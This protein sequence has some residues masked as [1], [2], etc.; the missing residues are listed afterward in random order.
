MKFNLKYC[1]EYK[2]G[3]NYYNLITKINPNYKLFYNVKDK[4]FII[5]NSAKN[6]EI[7]LN[8]NNFNQNI[9]KILN[10]SKVENSKNIFYSIENHNNKLLKKLNEKIKYESIE[11]IKILKNYL[12]KTPII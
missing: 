12:S 5:V 6:Y 11:Q 4:C 3:F 7:C 8:F 2:D 1:F 9:E 10:L